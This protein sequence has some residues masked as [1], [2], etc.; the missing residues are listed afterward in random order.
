[1]KRIIIAFIAVSSFAFLLSPKFYSA[2]KEGFNKGALFSL[3]KENKSEKGFKVTNIGSF[4]L[5]I[6]RKI[7][8]SQVK[9]PQGREA[10]EALRGVNKIVIVDYEEASE[11]SKK[12]FEGR[13]SRIFRNTEK[14]FEV[15]EDGDK[16]DLYGI[17][18]DDGKIIKDFVLFSSS[19]SALICVI[20]S[21]STDRIGALINKNLN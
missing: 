20:G 1:M 17:L 16:M 9:D 5:S 18:S 6:M 15:K 11:A 8:S 19:G 12:R 4:G 14:L 7:A 13:V 21:I 10:I 3:I 2:N